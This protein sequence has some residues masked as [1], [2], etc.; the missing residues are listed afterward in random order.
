[1]EFEQAA[2]EIVPFPQV[3]QGDPQVGQGDF[4]VGQGDFRLAK[5]GGFT[6]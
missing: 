4:R 1:M 6:G 5:V 2:L 3:G